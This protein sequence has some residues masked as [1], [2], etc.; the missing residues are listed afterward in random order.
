MLAQ[1]RLAAVAAPLPKDAVHLEISFPQ[2]D[3]EIDVPPPPP[4]PPPP[5]GAK[6]AP[7]PPPPPA[8]RPK[9]KKIALKPIVFHV[10]AVPDQGATWLGFGL[11]PKLLAQRAVAALSSTSD[12]SSLGKTPAA[13]PLKSAKVNG[14]WMITL[15]GL[16]VFTALKHSSR[17]P[18]GMLSSTPNQGRSPIVLT[19]AAKGPSQEAAAGSAVSTFKLPRG[20]IEDIVRIAF[21]SR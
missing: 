19:F 13:E 20:A 14:A 6:R 21:A 11:D 18:Y 16:L 17:S 5:P 8:A 1:M 15:R 3:L 9:P 4:P 2:H 12:A 10:I 7:P